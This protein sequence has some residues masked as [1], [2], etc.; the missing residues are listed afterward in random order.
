VTVPPTSLPTSAV[1]AWWTTAW[2]RG[3]VVTDHVL[4]AVAADGRLHLG[5]DGEPLAVLLAR[6]R[7]AGATG[8]GL[9]LPVAGDPLGLGGPA[10]LTAAALEHGEALVAPDAGLGLVPATAA[11]TVTWH[12]HA[13]RARSVPDVGEADRDL[14]RAL[15]EAAG[16]LADLDVA[17][18][19]PEA[20]DLLLGPG[21]EPP[22]PAPAG[23]PP[24]CVELAG[25]GLR[26]GAVVELALDDD[27]GALSASEISRRR[28]AL[29]P[30]ERVARRA[31]VAACSPEAWPPG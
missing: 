27:G 20:A 19:R 11:E 3:R 23:T 29:L 2:L 16:A 24:R 21:R 25:R 4:D 28:E 26:A 31:V 13:A 8:C 5:E 10:T 6:L 30:L 15:V 12:T 22:L 14:R 18:W 7:R 1:L 17:R 9:A